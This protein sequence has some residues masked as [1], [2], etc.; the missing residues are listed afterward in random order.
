MINYR[1]MKTE[2]IL[3]L[4][5]SAALSDEDFRDLAKLT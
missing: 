5:P 3:V 2:A 1:I 4:E